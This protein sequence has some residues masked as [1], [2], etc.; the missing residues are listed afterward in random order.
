[1]LV[2]QIPKVAPVLRLHPCRHDIERPDE[3]THYNTQC[4]RTRYG[5][6]VLGD[7]EWLSLGVGSCR[8]NNNR[9]GIAPSP[10]LAFGNSKQLILSLHG[11][12]GDF[13]L[14]QDRNLVEVEFSSSLCGGS[15]S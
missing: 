13:N 14:Y 12:E 15:V 10:C 7:M 2:L 4:P 6:A 11:D 3:P 9:K 5:M 8:E 1:M